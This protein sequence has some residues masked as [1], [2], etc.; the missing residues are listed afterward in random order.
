MQNLQRNRA[1]FAVALVIIVLIALLVYRNFLQSSLAPG[2]SSTASNAID[3]LAGGPRVSIEASGTGKYTIQDVTG[4]TPAQDVKSSPAAFDFGKP[5]VFSASISPEVRSALNANLTSAQATLRQKPTDFS[6]LVQIGNLH[7]MGGDD[8]EAER[9][10]LYVASIYPSSTVPFD[11][12]GSLYL[13]FLKNYAKAEANFKRAI[14][15]NPHDISAYQQLFSLY[16]TYGYR[17]DT[18][19]AADLTAQG[20]KD[21]PD[22][23]TLLQ[24]KAQLEK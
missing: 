19:T 4:K 7:H 3:F 23:Q 14:E 15:I 2:A 8:K 17:K 5:I 16:T 18:K 1:L 9:I 21:N 22:N 13:D 11:N 24:L 20:L 10:Y 12:L 6:A